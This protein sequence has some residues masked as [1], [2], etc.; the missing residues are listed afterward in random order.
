M[1][2][3][4]S[5]TAAAMALSCCWLVVPGCGA[6]PPADPGSPAETV[7][8]AQE[9]LSTCVVVQRGT[10]GVVRDTQVVRRLATPLATDPDANANAHTDPKRA[11]RPTLRPRLC[12][13]PS[14]SR[15]L[16][17]QATT[18]GGLALAA[19]G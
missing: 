11:I 3:P 1:T 16:A 13:Q 4:R 7:A 14:S 10:F 18:S 15:R 19:L 6:E 5:V 2:I 17:A 12:R 9:G 8:S